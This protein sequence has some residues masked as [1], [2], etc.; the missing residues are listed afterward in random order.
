[1]IPKPSKLT[2]KK[3]ILASSS[4]RR[5]ELLKQVRLSFEAIPSKVDERIKDGESPVEHVVR[6]AEEKA[7]DVANN[8]KASWVIGADT[9]VLLD[10]EIMGKPT[11][12]EEAYQMLHKLSGKEHRVITGYCIFETGAQKSIKDHMETTV[13]FKELTEREI[14]GYIKTEEPFDK[15][16]GYTIQGMMGSFM[17]KEIKGSYTNVVGLPICELVEALQRVG[18]IKLFDSGQ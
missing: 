5:K 6:L 12:G 11:S 16:G 9:I 8:S 14:E 10:G 17:I 1:M 18:A 4:P 13:T 15:A 7:L 3:I 2:E